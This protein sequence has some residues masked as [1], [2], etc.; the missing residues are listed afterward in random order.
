MINDA[1]VPRGVELRTEIVDWLMKLIRSK[2]AEVD[3]SK[4]IL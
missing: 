3:F 2:S 4:L 1:R